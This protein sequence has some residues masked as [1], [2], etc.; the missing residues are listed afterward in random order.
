LR[1]ALTWFYPWLVFAGAVRR[2][3]VGVGVR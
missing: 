3:K 1:V 2:S